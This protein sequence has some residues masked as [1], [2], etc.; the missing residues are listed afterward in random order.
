MLVPLNNLGLNKICSVLV[1]L[2]LVVLGAAY[3]GL[4]LRSCAS[5]GVPA[6]AQAQAF[7]DSRASRAA[8]E[9]DEKIACSSP[10]AL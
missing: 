4:L 2:G 9:G 7:C 6:H 8:A 10:V 1:L 3:V 5:K